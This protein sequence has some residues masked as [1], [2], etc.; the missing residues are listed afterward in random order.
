LWLLAAAL[1]CAV[2]EIIFRRVWLKNQ[3]KNIR[4]S[5]YEISTETVSHTYE[6]SYV[7]NKGRGLNEAV[8]NSTLYFESGK[9]WKIPKKNYLWSEERPM[10][11]F[12]V[13]RSAHR[14]DLFTA[15]TQK[16]TGEIVVAYHNDF[17][18]Y[19]RK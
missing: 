12:A 8:Y 14:G 11:G 5:D 10:S 2:G 1:V 6:E 16:D 17:F 15:V 4:L 13:C 7:V 3:I 18:E 19:K 9:L